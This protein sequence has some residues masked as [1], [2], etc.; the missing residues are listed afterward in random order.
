[1]QRRTEAT[2][3]S[4]QHDIGARTSNWCDCLLRRTRSL[5]PNATRWDRLRHSLFCPP[6]VNLGRAYAFL[7]AVPIIWIAGYCLAGQEMLVNGNLF[8]LYILFIV[9]LLGGWCME[10]IGLPG[11]L[12]ML[13]AGMI[14]GN[15]ERQTGWMTHP[16]H[17]DWSAKTRGLALIVIF[18]CAGL[19]LNPDQLRRL[20]LIVIRLAFIPCVIEAV[21]VACISYF[22]LGFPWTWAFMLGFALSAASTAIVVPCMLKIQREGYGV[23][24]GVPTMLT[25][26]SSIDD[27]F[28]IS[29]FAI[30]LGLTF[31]E[32][33]IIRKMFMPLAEVT[34]GILY[35]IIFGIVLWFV[36]NR[37]DK[38]AIVEIRSILL[39]LGGIVSYFGSIIIEMHS[40]GA[41]GVLTMAFVASL[42]WRTQ[43]YESDNPVAL[44]F[45]YLWC[46]F[47]PLIFGLIGYEIDFTQIKLTT[48]GY[49]VIVIIGGL[50]FRCCASY[51]ALH[52]GNFNVKEKVF[53]SIAWMPK[54]IVQ[55]AIGPSALDA[56]QA[57]LH[58]NP[59]Y[60]EWGR[61]IVTIVVTAILFRLPSER[62]SWDFTP[63][64][65]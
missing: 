53:S 33:S 32:G 12:G 44:N 46:I 41:L 34:V 24:K 15:L 29:I 9:C 61:D 38:F 17:Q 58:P 56:A 59:Q 36:P 26:A 11:L 7:L 40:G 62:S 14:V 5:S 55:A 18:I 30:F 23:D 48:I 10:L 63:P 25:A 2:F 57:M 39:L 19:E 21:T 22:I 37:K 20:S 51:F 13:F 50:F 1:M 60:I 54:A 3:S 47:E 64:S 28:A 65:Y 49:G 42:G 52:G 31:S 35:G 4:D 16:I 27:I 43:G 6:G 8:Q 45:S